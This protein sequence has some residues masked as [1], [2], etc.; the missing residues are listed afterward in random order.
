MNLTENT[1]ILPDEN[2]LALFVQYFWRVRAKNGAG[3]VSPWSEEW[4]FTV[5]PIG[6]I[7]ALLMPLL[8]LLP[9]A[10]MLRRQNRKY[11]K[12]RMP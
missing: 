6:A 7:G 9:F 12:V 3:N 10:L 2:A 4:N 5:V 1:Y 11:P 8:M